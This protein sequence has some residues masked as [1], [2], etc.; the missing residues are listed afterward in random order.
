[1]EAKLEADQYMTPEDFI[2]DARLVFANC[3]K[4]NDENTSYAKCANKLEKYMWQQIK[5]NPGMVTFAAVKSH[6]YPPLC[7]RV[8]FIHAHFVY[9]FFDVVLGR[10]FWT[11]T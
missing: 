6:H 8:V 7:Q 5:C 4:Y 11:E 3:R 9:R 1:M 2:K 10:D